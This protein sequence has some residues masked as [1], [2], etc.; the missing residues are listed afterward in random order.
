MS[1]SKDV[2]FVLVPG[3]AGYTVKPIDLLSANDG[4]RLPPAQ[5]ADDAAHIRDHIISVLDSGKNVVLSL[6]SYAGFPGSEATK[7]LSQKYRGPDAT[8]VIGI[9]YAASFLPEE[10][11]SLRDT[12][13]AYMPEAYMT[14]VP[15]GYFPPVPPELAGAAFN[16]MTDQGELQKYG[17]AFTG[18]S[19]DSYSGVLS[20]AAWKDI[21]G[22]TIIPQLDLIVPTEEQERQYEHAVENGGK[23]KRVAVEGG[24][25][26]ITV[27]QP[28][29]VAN[30]LIALAKA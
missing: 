4:S 9:A 12:M 2:V 5:M 10:G 26:G 23:I 18:H 27:T 29:L 8:A 11:K 20:Y 3:K 25:H 30:E 15:G 14:G 16:D 17:Q 24:G 19:S 13:A 1:T 7:G 22:T 6:Q 21:P 28:Q